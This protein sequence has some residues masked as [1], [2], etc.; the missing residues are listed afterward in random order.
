MWIHRW[1]GTR[2]EVVRG[3]EHQCNKVLATGGGLHTYATACKLRNGA[4]L[5]DDSNNAMVMM[6]K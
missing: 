3:G 5:A 1:S 2:A 4:R 6:R